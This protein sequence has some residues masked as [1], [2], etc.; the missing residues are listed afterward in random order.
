LNAQLL[1]EQHALAAAT[2]RIRDLQSDRDAERRALAW[3]L[4][5]DAITSDGWSN[6]GPLAR[7]AF[8]SVDAFFD[9]ETEHDDGR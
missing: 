4:Y 2:D 7:H 3:Q 8:E 9:M 1:D 5:R 6:D